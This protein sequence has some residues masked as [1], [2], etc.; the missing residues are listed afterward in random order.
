MIFF[1]KKNLAIFIPVNQG[2][3]PAFL[4]FGKLDV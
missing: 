1:F 3:M 4:T 2:F